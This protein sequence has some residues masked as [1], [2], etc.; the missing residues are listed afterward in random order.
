MVG[1]GVTSKLGHLYE[2]KTS[3]AFRNHVTELGFVHRDP[4]QEELHGARLADVCAE[5]PTFAG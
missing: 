2:I 5:D 1:S 4:A 3:I